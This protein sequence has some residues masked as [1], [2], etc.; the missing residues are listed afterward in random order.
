MHRPAKSSQKIRFGYHR[1][2]EK[3]YESKERSITC[4]RVVITWPSDD[5][6]SSDVIIF[7]EGLSLSFDLNK[8]SLRLKYFVQIRNVFVALEVLCVLSKSAY[9]SL[10]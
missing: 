10:L 7:V 3:I 5:I 8:G 6:A 4:L 9:I 2:R 1:R